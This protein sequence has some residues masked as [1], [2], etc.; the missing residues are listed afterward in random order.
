MVAANNKINYDKNYTSNAGNFDCHADTVVQCRVHCLME[1]IRGFMQCHLMPPSGKCLCH[2]APAAAMIDG[3][4][5][6]K[7][8]TNKTQL[9]PSLC[10]VDRQKKLS[11]IDTQ[12][13][14]STH[15][16]TMTSPDSNP[17][18][19]SQVEAFSFILS[20]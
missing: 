10:T 15:V 18:A 19:A 5:K 7:K 14:P 17:C 13:R 16:L 4:E 9:L 12:Q 1:R 8:N 11:N 2:I 20:Y 3:F 6:K